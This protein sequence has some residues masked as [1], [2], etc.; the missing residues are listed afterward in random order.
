MATGLPPNI[1]DM[2]QSSRTMLGLPK[3]PSVFEAAPPPAL[4]RIPGATTLGS[5]G[6]ARYG[7]NSP[8]AVIA[9]NAKRFGLD[10]AAV[11]A[12]ALEESGAHYGAVGD[13]GTSFGPFQAHIGGAAGN[14]TTQAA[15][16]W[17]NSPAGLIQMMGM[18][19]RGG[20]RG[21]TGEAA[22]RAIYSG[23]GKG[24]PLA[25]P[26]GIAQ[27]QNA[28]RVLQGG[29][30][31]QDAVSPWGGKVPPA[32]VG[33]WVT[34]AAGADRQ[35]MPTQ[36]MVMQFV[37]QVAQVFGQRLTIGT[38]SNHHKYVLG[39]GN[40]I[41]DHWYGD[42]ADIPMTGSSLTRLGQ[43]ALI[44]AGANPAWARKQTGGVFNVNGYNILFNTHVGGNHF[45]HLHV[46]LGRRPGSR[47]G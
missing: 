37:S 8:V 31:P 33:R 17:A 7:G 11:L 5:G 45:N 22:V 19:S 38:G 40:T 29:A 12:Y 10:P 35:G 30:A 41:S 6:G 34:V 4:P 42:A 43:D 28:L 24:T 21:L 46:G 44:A 26:K 23:F 18:M 1:F 15:S 25:I 39:E 14:R 32:N 47:R 20:A 36:P 2:F 9:Q 3:L 27:Y 16:S 13:Q